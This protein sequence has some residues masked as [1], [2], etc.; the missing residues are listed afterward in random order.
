MLA[1]F[2]PD[3]KALGYQCGTMKAIWDN[4]RGLDLLEDLDYVAP[5]FGTIGHSLGGHN[6]IYTAVF[7]PRIRAVVSSC[8]FDS[9]LDYKDGKIDGWAQERYMPRIKTYALADIPFDFHD[10]IAALAPRPCF[11][12]APLHDSNFK[13]RSVDAVT[14]AA[15][16]VYDLYGAPEQLRVEHPDCAHD[17]PDEMRELAYQLFEAHLK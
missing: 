14:E 6:S 7:E 17:F 12:S 15:S 8:G 11:V 4:I 3:L 13:W 1:E 2:Q 10:L 9:Y 16:R 5:H